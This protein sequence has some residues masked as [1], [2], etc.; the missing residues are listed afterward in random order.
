MRY[1]LSNI[2]FFTI[3]AI[4]S[5]IAGFILAT[6]KVSRQHKTFLIREYTF[7]IVLCVL[8]FVVDFAFMPGY[9]LDMLRYFIMHH[10]VFWGL[11][12]CATSYVY[13]FL[14]LAGLF[15]ALRA[16]PFVGKFLQ[17]LAWILLTVPYSMFVIVTQTRPTMQNIF[18]LFSVKTGTAVNTVMSLVTPW[19]AVRAI[20]PNIIVMA[21][22]CAIYRR[23][24]WDGFRAVRIFTGLLVF[25]AYCINPKGEFVVEDFMG[26]SL[27]TLRA[28]IRGLQYLSIPRDTYTASNPRIPQDNVLLIVDESIRGDYL[29]INNPEIDTTPALTKYL[30]DYPGNMLSYGVIVAAATSSSLGRTSVLSGLSS[31]PDKKLDVFRKP[32]VFSIAKANGYRTV[33][34]NVQGDFP[35]LL[36]RQSDM[37]DADEVYLAEG[38]L[39]A[40]KE[41]DADFHA[42]EY[43]R[44]RLK[45]ER[46][47]FIFLEKMGAHIPY[48][49]RYPGHDPIN[50]IFMPK[51]DKGERHTFDKRRKVVNS[52]KNC[53]RY[54]IDGF[55]TRLLGDDPLSLEDCT[56]IYTSD[57]GQSFMEYGQIESHTTGYLEQALTPLLV[58]TT[59]SWV[60]GNLRRP[61]S[62]PGTLSGMNIYPTVKS[63]LSRENECKSG[64]YIS[65]LS[66]GEWRNA[67]LV[68]LKTPPLWSGESSQPAST[69]IDGRI[70]LPTG[71]Y[72]Y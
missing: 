70:I 15:V 2:P 35:D 28:S 66:R 51:M 39:D 18:D 47:L 56:V 14:A 52:Y 63:V 25:A 30:H 24:S 17:W 61:E 4:L 69:D 13:L 37:K 55:F 45:E 6:P 72:M 38:I 22:M 71:K 10:T 3:L 53:L 20:I 19:A 21:A 46:G 32:T 54:N 68:W 58:F 40:H 27:K 59:D 1:I 43:I 41:I 34:I 29:S 50:Q 5:L 42:A 67:P 44:R 48:E 7:C 31:I 64:E 23:R 62:V 57:H 33:L 36:F 12:V 65:L 60:L 9:I 26:Y 8:T 11:F 49:D 16:V